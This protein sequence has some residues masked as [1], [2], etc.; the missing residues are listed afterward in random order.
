M[1]KEYWIVII[2]IA[3]TIATTIATTIIVIIFKNWYIN[4][5]E[6]KKVI[7]EFNK[8]KL[9]I[10]SKILLNDYNFLRKEL[11]TFFMQ[12]NTILQQ[13]EFN[14][15]FEKWLFKDPSVDHPI[16]A[17]GYSSEDFNKMQDELSKL[18][19]KL[20]YCKSK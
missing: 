20:K 3:G 9:K 14:Y 12:H 16:S 2:T 15:F 7:T 18:D 6:K 17:M 19:I 8:L 13:P 1:N 5:Q 4:H 11:K 10:S